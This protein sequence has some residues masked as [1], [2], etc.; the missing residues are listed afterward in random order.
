M[1]ENV[2]K[3]ADEIVNHRAQEKE[4]QYGPFTE[5]MR[6]AAA[7]ATELCNKE[8]TTDDFF[9]CMMALKLSRLAF[10]HKPDT[11]VDLAAYLGALS[12]KLQE[13]DL[14]RGQDITAGKEA[15]Q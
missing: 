9:K 11:F 8:I 6:K 3:Q 12:N 5:S 13:D 14:N 10:S 2:L 7:I 4:R 15:G 1:T